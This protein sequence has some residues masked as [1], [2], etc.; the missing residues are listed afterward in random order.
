[1]CVC[2]KLDPCADARALWNDVADAHNAL[3]RKLRQAGAHSTMANGSGAVVPRQGTI[4]LES[5][6]HDA[7]WRYEQHFEEAATQERML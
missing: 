3:V 2:T 4:A 5:A 1:M 7:L 6:Y